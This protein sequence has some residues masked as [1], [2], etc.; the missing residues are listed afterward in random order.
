MRKFWKIFGIAAV[1][2]LIGVAA[3]SAVAL[4]QGPGGN[5]G[6]QGDRPFGPPG[7]HFSGPRQ[8]GFLGNEDL[9]AQMHEALAEALGMSVAD[10]E[11]AKAEGQT[12]RDMVEAQG[13]DL[14][15]VRAAMAT[16][17]QAAIDQAVADGRL[18]QEQAD[19]LGERFEARPF[20]PG[21]SFAPHNGG[22]RHGGFGEGFGPRGFWNQ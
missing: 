19:R 16:V 22:G 13:V 20:G 17:R 2:A 14:A 6:F 15:E 11:A 5:R 10:F 1:A 18:T 12:V 3:L 8:S 9:K 4:A 21:G 7:G